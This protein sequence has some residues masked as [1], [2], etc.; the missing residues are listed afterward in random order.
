ME[1]QNAAEELSLEGLELLLGDEQAGIKEFDAA[2]YLEDPASIAAYLTRM[3]ENDDDSRLAGALK[4][5]ARA[6]G[7][8]KVAEQTGIGKEAL[9]DQA[10]PWLKAVNRVLKALG[11]KIVIV[12]ES[13]Q[14][15]V[16][17]DY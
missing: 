5:V 2:N 6:A 15:K 3:L 11:M 10:T 8:A 12:P 9:L 1:F 7:M 16:A 4:D 13:A 17:Q 14:S